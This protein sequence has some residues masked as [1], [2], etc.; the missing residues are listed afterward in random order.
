MK[1]R[2]RKD[3]WDNWQFYE[4]DWP[5]AREIFSRSGVVTQSK[6]GRLDSEPKKFGLKAVD[7]LSIS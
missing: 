2:G 1:S 3:G 4:V 5:A 7:L 6:T